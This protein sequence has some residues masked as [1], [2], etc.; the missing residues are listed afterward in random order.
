M[1]QEELATSSPTKA[2]KAAAI[3]GI[4]FS[5]LL[6]F[7]FVLFLKSLPANMQNDGAWLL[8]QGKTVLLGLN[9]V[10]FAGIAFLWFMGVVRD[11]LG[12]HEDRFISTVFLGSGILFVALLFTVAAMTGAV[13][14]LYLAERDRFLASNFYSFGH[15]IISEILNTYM[16]KMA[17]VF[18]MSTSTLF[19]RARVIPKWIGY[20]GYAL[21][22]IMLLRISHLDRLGWVSLSF[23]LW[24]LLVSFNILINNYHK[25]PRR[26]VT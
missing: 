21:A 15:L 9:L 14:L 2:P 13:V 8:T 6:I 1:M 22:A 3:A 24:V 19:L 26:V 12:S 16:L 17:G 23:P 18:M 10:P 5:I 25:E 20:L 4:V 11:R 7:S